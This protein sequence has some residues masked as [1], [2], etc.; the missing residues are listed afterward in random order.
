MREEHAREIGF[1]GKV[2]KLKVSTLGGNVVEKAST[3]YDCHIRDEA[4][5]LHSFTAYGLEKVVGEIE[6]SLN[7]DMLRELFPSLS[8]PELMKLI[9]MKNVD[10]LMGLS[11]P[12]W[13]PE[14]AE[15]AR[16]VEGDLWVFRSRFG[17]CVAGSHPDLKDKRD[18]IGSVHSVLHVYKAEVLE[19]EIHD[20]EFCP[21]R[22]S[23]LCA[24]GVLKMSEANYFEYENLG[25]K[26]D[27]KCSK[28]P[29]PGSKYGFQEQ[30]ELDLICENLEYDPNKKRWETEYPWKVPRSTLPKNDAIALQSLISVEKSLKKNPEWAGLYCE[31]V[32]EM[33][34]R[35]VVVVLESKD[36]EWK[37]DYYYLP[38]L[39]VKQPKKASTPVRLCFDASRRQGGFPSLNDCLF[40]GPDSYVA[41]LLTVLVGFRSK[42]VRMVADIKKFHNRIFLKEKDI[43]MQRFLWRDMKVE[44]EPKVDAVVVNNIGVKSANCVATCAKDKTAD[45]YKDRFPKACEVLVDQT[46]IDDILSSEDSEDQAKTRADE[47]EEILREGGMNTK[48]WTFSG[49]K[50]DLKE[51][52]SLK[53]EELETGERVL[54]VFWEPG[55]D[56][57]KFSINFK[58]GPANITRRIVL[59]QVARIY[60][61]CGWLTPFLLK[62]K[63]LLRETWEDRNGKALGWD[64]LLP[65]E[66]MVGW[67]EF[68]EE[69]KELQGVEFSRSLRPEKETV[70]EAQLIMFSDGSRGAF[71]AV[72]YIRWEFKEG[73]FWSRLIMSKGKLGPKRMLTIPRMELNGALVSSRIS[74]FLKGSTKLKIGEVKHFV[75]SSTVLGYINKDLR[76]FQVYE[77]VRVAEIQS[78]GEFEGG[79]LKGWGWV[80]GQ[81]NQS[82]WVTKP[83]KPGDLKSND[84]WGKGPKWL[85]DNEETWPV[86]Y[87]FKTEKLEGEIEIQNVHL[88]Q[89][90]SE[91]GFVQMERL[92]KNCSSWKRLVR[93]TARLFRLV[94]LRSEPADPP[95]KALCK[96]EISSTTN[97]VIKYVQKT[98]VKDLEESTY[99]E[100]ETN[101]PKGKFRRL[102][103]VKD[104]TGVWR[105]GSRLVEFVP[106]TEDFA[107][108]VLRLLPYDHKVS[109]LIM[110]ECHEFGHTGQDRTLARFRAMG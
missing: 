5:V 99:K 104:D 110:R 36:L 95:T 88:V 89:E 53:D 39:A 65:E 38:H 18:V 85:E 83:R 55:R 34:D 94:R 62:A 72:A 68:E 22:S 42:E 77:G 40:K 70:G 11:H 75:D 50:K 46:Y 74:K 54:G 24:V 97:F 80:P 45:M 92:I 32:Q 30:R 100:G 19:S 52:G 76:Q 63:I 108:P 98:M 102:A 25:T 105:V 13:H 91:D 35:G 31:Q 8:E 79:R 28:C 3:L 16:T 107:L 87:S 29:A 57:F 14:K 20:F 41:N 103:P 21:K 10:F 12:S 15:R 66:N 81:E 1:K 44:E 7:M 9:R 56:V 58:P 33:K 64:E 82:Y 59:S 67:R 51:L 4:G 61:P 101:K 78:E 69:A 60:D 49:E 96:D 73:G 86:R 17:T 26:V 109:R 27:P 23:E 37:G 84:F 106:F 6:N 47:I 43:H 93:T 2:V 71:G 48:G 90:V